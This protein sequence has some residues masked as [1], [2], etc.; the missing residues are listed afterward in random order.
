MILLASDAVSDVKRLRSFLEA[1]NP[2]AAKR[3]LAR[4]WAV[5]ERV[6]RL[7]ELGR[8]TEDA[9]IR[10]IVIK[11]GAAGYIVRYRVLADTGDLFVT[12]IWHGREGR[13]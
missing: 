6:E 10:Q 1:R 13:R 3:A 2:D 7:P 8:A 4:I 5:L 9:D 12:R 11:F